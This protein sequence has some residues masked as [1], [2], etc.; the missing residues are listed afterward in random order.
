MLS[1]FYPPPPPPTNPIQMTPYV[2]FSNLESNRDFVRVEHHK[3]VVE[4]AV[5]LIH[6]SVLKTAGTNYSSGL[7]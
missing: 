3:D 7:I 6:I 4:V 1:H 2:R 5:V